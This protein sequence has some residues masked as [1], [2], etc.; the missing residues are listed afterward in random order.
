MVAK[1]LKIP[2]CISLNIV[3]YALHARPFQQSRPEHVMRHN[4]KR[5]P[6]LP[7]FIRVPA[8]QPAAAPIG[9]RRIQL[10]AGPLAS[11]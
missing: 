6:K 7:H 3:A 10:R 4:K 2:A 5:R 9:K 1:S 11:P 8:N